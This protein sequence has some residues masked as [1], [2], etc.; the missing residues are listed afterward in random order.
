M[1]KCILFVPIFLLSY[2]G[3]C[4]A[5]LDRK[6]LLQ[7]VTLTLEDI[8]DLRLKILAAQMSSGSF[9]ILD[10]GSVGF[11]VSIEIGDSLGALSKSSD[12][13]KVVFTIRG[14]IDDHQLSR[15]EQKEIIEQ[16]IAVVNVGISQLFEYDFRQLRFDR[17]KD[18]V[19]YWY[20]SEASFPSAK[21]ERG[22]FI[23]LK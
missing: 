15:D 5:Q 10:M 23:W 1:K 16:S 12:K 2:C 4:H 7:T 8:L 3:T 22:E 21:W 9:Y 20:F 14:R 18:I 19:G 17:N 6:Q 11:P 13:R